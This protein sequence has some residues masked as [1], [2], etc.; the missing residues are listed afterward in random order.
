MFRLAA[1]SDVHSDLQALEDTLAAIERAQCDAIVCCGDLVDYGLFPD[2]TLALL[3]TRRIPCVRGNHDRWTVE[4]RS[5]QGGGW[6]LS[7]GS[8][9]FLTSL[10][11][12]Y[13]LES[14][15]V[16][17][18]VHHG[19]PRG[20]MD[21]VLPTEIEYELAREHLVAAN[22]DVLLVGHTHVAFALNVDGVGMIA[23]PAA[24]LRDPADGAE[25]PPATGSFGILELPSRRFSVHRAKDGAE[26]EIIRR[27]MTR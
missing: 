11:S 17:V 7:K 21:G 22:A 16:R 3:A 13:A 26:L 1:I 9:K 5:D 6:D 23:N 14:E 15:G 18:A 2:E 27:R 20:D 24:V 4:G 12:T 10:P 8:R 25:N 19:S